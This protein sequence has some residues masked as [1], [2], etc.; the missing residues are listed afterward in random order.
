MAREPFGDGPSSNERRAREQFERGKSDKKDK[1]DKF[2]PVVSGVKQRKSGLGKKLAD[3]FIAN[4]PAYVRDYVFDRI[5]VPAVQDTLLD[6]VWGGLS[7]L[8]REGDV[9]APKRGR[10][11]SYYHD[12]YED[13]GVSKITRE[14]PSRGSERHSGTRRIDDLEFEERTDAE[15]VL[16][17]I[18]ALAEEYGNVAIADVFDICDMDHSYTDRDWGWDEEALSKVKVERLGRGKYTIY[19]PRAR[20]L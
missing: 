3:V 13:R 15:E 18:M 5:F 7:M 12:A 9:R 16:E 6:M 2:E 14:G 1:P 19:F 4:D 10:R 11:G 20:R 17:R 8:F